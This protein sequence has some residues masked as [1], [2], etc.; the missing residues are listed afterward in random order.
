MGRPLTK[1]VLFFLAMNLFAGAMVGMGVDQTIGLD[2]RLGES[3]PTTEPTQEQIDR[4]PS[5][6]LVSDASDTE[7]GTGQGSTL[8]GMYNTLSRGVNSLYEYVFPALTILERAGLLPDEIETMLEVI[9]S[10]MIGIAVLSYTRGWD[11]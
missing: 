6:E 8:F 2:T 5:C 3:C 1:L 7:T 4:Y 11:L 9:F 10:F